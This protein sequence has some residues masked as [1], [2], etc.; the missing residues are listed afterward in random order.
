MNNINTEYHNK[1]YKELG[2]SSADYLSMCLALST[3]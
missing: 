3:E 1:K 2:S